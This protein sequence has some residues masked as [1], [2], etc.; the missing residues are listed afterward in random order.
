[1]LHLYFNYFFTFVD[2]PTVNECYTW[3]FNYFF[4]FLDRPTVNEC[5]IN[6]VFNYF[7]NFLDFPTVNECYTW[8][9]NY[10]FTFL[11][12]LTE[13]TIIGI[14][15]GVVFTIGVIVTLLCC[16]C[17]MKEKCANLRKRLCRCCYR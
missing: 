7:I 5:Y 9:F 2:C 10:F 4:T 11:E 8:Y 15:V 1:M 3:Y 13:S 17:C 16:F 6:F 12:G 14:V